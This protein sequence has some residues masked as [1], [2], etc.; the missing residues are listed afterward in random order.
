MKSVYTLWLSAIHLVSYYVESTSFDIYR[1]SLSSCWYIDITFEYFK[2]SF[3][4][5][6]VS[7]IAIHT[8]FMNL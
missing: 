3:K 4:E 2:V 5:L 7:L 1:F 8:L 6:S